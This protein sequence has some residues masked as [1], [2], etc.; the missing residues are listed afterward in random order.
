MILLREDLS[1]ID[2]VGYTDEEAE[3]LML[4]INK[5]INDAIEF[6]GDRDETAVCLYVCAKL[7]S[8]ILASEVEIRKGAQPAYI[9]AEYLFCTLKHLSLN[10]YKKAHREIKCKDGY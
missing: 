4:S 3:G 2:G 1:I 8:R 5:A 6:D 7:I 9:L 10:F